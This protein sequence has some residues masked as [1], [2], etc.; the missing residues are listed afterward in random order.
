M[1][2][3]PI[4]TILDDLRS[5]RM[6]V[7]VDDE[8]RENE[9]DLV[10]AAQHVTPEIV[11]FMTK[12]AR[13]VL[14]VA[15]DGATCDRLD[16]TPQSSHNTAQLGTAFTVTVDA[17]ARFGLTT[18]V[19][20]SDRATTIAVLADPNASPND[21]ARPGHINPLR[22]RDGGVL[23]RTGQTEGGVDLC[24]LAGLEPAAVIIEVMNDDGSMARRPELEKLCETHDLNMCSVADVVAHRMAGE[25][26]VERIDEVPVVTPEGEFRLIAYRSLVDPLPHVALVTGRVGRETDIT[27]P[28]LVR[29]HPQN[30]LGDVFGDAAESSGSTLH[31]AMRQVREAGEGA[32]VYMR[33]DAMGTGLIQKLHTRVAPPGSHADP[34]APDTFIEPKEGK[35]NIGIGSQILRDL[36]LT[37]LRVITDHPI[38]YHGLEGFGLTIDDWVS[39]NTD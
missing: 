30:I 9:G 31:A 11:N 17:A 4:Q 14:C 35:L 21:L 27:D 8:K 36:G 22:A 33:Q 5:G 3:A 10:C 39:V 1:P 23:V 26:L 38:H 19:S 13:G 32:I 12:H 28:V 29:V 25:K 2:F 34:N 7:L 37:R 24:K 18:G 15:L 16:L 20:A 6:V